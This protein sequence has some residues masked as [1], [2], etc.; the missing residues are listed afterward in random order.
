MEIATTMS[1]P[2]QMPQ[3]LADISLSDEAGGIQGQT[4]QS[5]CFG[6]L[7]DQCAAMAGV[8]R[9][10]ANSE[11]SQL[12]QSRPQ[13]RAQTELATDD[14]QLNDPSHGS[15]LRVKDSFT[16]G[17]FK[18]ATATSDRTVQELSEQTVADSGESDHG[19]VVNPAAGPT[20]GENNVPETSTLQML[21]G[22]QQKI[23]KGGNT[24]EIITE[25]FGELSSEKARKVQVMSENPAALKTPHGS[26]I[27]S[28]EGGQLA[29]SSPAENSRGLGGQKKGNRFSLDFSVCSGQS[30]PRRR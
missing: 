26:P 11:S 24:G 30:S 27:L 9:L 28:T 23:V 2:S 13:R 10:P 8:E 14:A 18:M 7:F 16:E 3:A 5:P 1:S 12:F 21:L 19:K 22:L 17:R 4:A 25:T 29:Y 15:L 6:L 20:P